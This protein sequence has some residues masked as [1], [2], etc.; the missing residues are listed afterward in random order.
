MTAFSRLKLT[1]SPSSTGPKTDAFSAP[2]P[3]HFRLHV[4]DRALLCRRS[5][6]RPRCRQQQHVLESDGTNEHAYGSVFDG[7]AFVVVVVSGF[8][9]RLGGRSWRQQRSGGFGGTN[10][11]AVLWRG[12]DW[13]H[14]RLAVIGA[15]AF[16]CKQI[17][18]RDPLRTTSYFR[19]L[20]TF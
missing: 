12:A 15:L 3:G 18:L 8:P 19:E 14:G 6:I 2:S 9:D 20:M 7:I 17:S 4:P 5:D 13:R 1:R 16:H 11:R 10:D